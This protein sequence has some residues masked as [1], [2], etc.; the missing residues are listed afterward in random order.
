MIMLG[1]GQLEEKLVNKLRLLY[2]ILSKD[3]CKMI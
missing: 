3:A 1:E 2:S